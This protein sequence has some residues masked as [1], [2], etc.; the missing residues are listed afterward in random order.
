[1]FKTNTFKKKTNHTLLFFHI[2]HHLLIFK[3]TLFQVNYFLGG[4]RGNLIV[5]SMLANHPAHQHVSPD[6][7]PGKHFL[8]DPQVVTFGFWNN[9]YEVEMELAFGAPYVIRCLCWLSATLK[10][11]VAARP[12]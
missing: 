5:E 8:T 6:A 12:C 9:L 1:M 2:F 11:L 7:A 3:F 10:L 4:A